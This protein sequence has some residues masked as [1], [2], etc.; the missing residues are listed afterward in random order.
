MATSLATKTQNA[1][2]EGRTLILGAQILLGVLSRAVFEPGFQKMPEVSK[3]LVLG[4]LA[5]IVIATIILSSTRTS[6]ELC[7][8]RCCRLRCPSDSRSM[9]RQRWS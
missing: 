2:D 6:C 1:L 3:Y 5:L 4:S 8:L 7:S 9:W